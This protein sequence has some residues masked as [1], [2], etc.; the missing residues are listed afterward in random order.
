MPIFPFD[1]TKFYALTHMLD[2]LATK[3]RNS[4]QEIWQEYGFDPKLAF[5][6][7][8]AQCHGDF[9]AG[10][11]PVSEWIYPIPKNLRNADFLRNLGKE[12]V[13]QSITH[14]VKGTPMPPWGEV[15]PEKAEMGETP[16][17]TTQQIS[18]LADWLFSNIP[19]EAVI[20]NASELP[21]WEYSPRMIEQELNEMG[22]NTLQPPP[23]T[24]SEIFD[25]RPSP[26]PGP[27]AHG[28]YI[29][30][31]Y[32]TPENI[33]AGKDFFELNCAVC[34]GTE[35]DGAGPRAAYMQEAK[36]RMLINLDWIHT[37]D[38]LRLLRSIK[39]GVPGTAMVA[40]GDL[41]TPLQ[42]LQ[43]VM[44]I[45]SLTKDRSQSEQ[46]L[47]LIYK[48]FSTDLSILET[49]RINN[50]QELENAR[51]QYIKLQTQRETL[52]Q[53]IQADSPIESTPEPSLT[54]LYQQELDQLILIKQR[55]KI[56]H[57]YIERE[58]IL[59]AEETLYKNLGTELLNL[60]VD[61][62]LFNKY[63]ALIELNTNRYSLQNHTLEFHPAPHLREAIDTFMAELLT[64]IHSTL[65]T[66]SQEK[67][68][69]SA[70]LPSAERSETLNH[71]SAQ[72]TTYTKLQT[73]VNHTHSQLNALEERL[74]KDFVL[75]QA[76]SDQGASGPLESH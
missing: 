70:K 65:H 19:G 26:V 75:P 76:P 46:F 51:R 60:H 47:S 38:D 4:T 63:L 52:L 34:H 44:F 71:L 73:Q 57:L 18:L 43:L 42:R 25:V 17:L 58:N 69:A 41:T 68:L 56:D 48:V 24:H 14:G 64:Q 20:R 29:K 1:D 54:K 53:K 33:Q 67:E 12:R 74:W 2:A 32:Y 49:A 23:E 15:P 66:L 16:V 10:N 8:C 31:K 6:I 55:E 22:G 28:Y 11:G 27:D 3:N 30:Q 59:H 21:K 35:A 72:I 40:W 61:P 36:P 9:L 62:S 7:H 45:R 13:V 5:H 50:Y 39:Y 37:R